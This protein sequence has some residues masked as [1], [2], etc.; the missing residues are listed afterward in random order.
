MQSLTNY[1]TI[2]KCCSIKDYEL[3]SGSLLA[4]AV[5]C[6]IFCCFENCSSLSR[7]RR[8]VFFCCCWQLFIDWYTMLSFHKSYSLSKTRLLESLLSPYPSSCQSI[9]FFARLHSLSTSTAVAKINHSQY[10]SPVVLFF[11]SSARCANS[12]HFYYYL[13]PLLQLY[14]YLTPLLQQPLQLK[15]QEGF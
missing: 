11:A 1:P 5:A 13:T 8:L 6:I 9:G 4:S 10:K 15:W 2:A 3:K 7:R 14:H 12:S